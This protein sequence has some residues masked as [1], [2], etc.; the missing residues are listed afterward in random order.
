MDEVEALPDPAFLYCGAAPFLDSAA[1][2]AASLHLPEETALGVGDAF[3]V[4]LH[5]PVLD[6][7]I[8]HQFRA[9]SLGDDLHERGSA[10]VAPHHLT[11]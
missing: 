3:L 11:L 7:T 1:E 4:R 2:T 9:V 8:E 5:D 6:C 10:D